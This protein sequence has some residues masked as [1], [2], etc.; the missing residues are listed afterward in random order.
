ML[1]S[2]ERGGERV[3]ELVAGVDKRCGEITRGQIQLSLFRFKFRL[4]RL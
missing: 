1:L 2:V 4:F 3:V